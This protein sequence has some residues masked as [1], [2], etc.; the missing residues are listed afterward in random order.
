MLVSWKM[1]TL[2]ATFDPRRVRMLEASVLFERKEQQ[3]E[4]ESK[5]SVEETETEDARRVV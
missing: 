4:S 1:G 2:I 5:R 3:R